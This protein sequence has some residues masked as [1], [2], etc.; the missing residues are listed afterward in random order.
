[1][2]NQNKMM[3]LL[4]AFSFF[5]AEAVAKK[6]EA[7]VEVKSWK[8][9][10]IGIIRSDAGPVDRETIQKIVSEGADWREIRKIILDTLPDQPAQTGVFIERSNLCPD[11]IERPYVTYVPPAYSVSNPCPVLVWLHGGV[12]REKLID[13]PMQHANE[14]PLIPAAR[15]NGWIVILPFGQ[16]GATWWDPEGMDLI[17]TALKRTR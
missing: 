7:S 2:S 9:D 13:N 8:E 10:L 6:P 5:L 17:R 1:M 11:G 15:D 4:L 16:A 12:G 3:Y 14:N